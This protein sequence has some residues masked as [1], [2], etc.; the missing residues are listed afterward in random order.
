MDMTQKSSRNLNVTL[1]LL[2]AML[3]SVLLIIGLQTWLNFSHNRQQNEIESGQDLLELYKE[4]NNEVELQE[5]SSAALVNSFAVRPDVQQ[6]FLAR[7]RQG[8]LDLLTPIFTTLKNDYNVVHLY[9][10]E[11]EGVVF[12]RV[13]N[14]E[15]F[16]DSVTYRHTAAAAIESRQTT[17]GVEIG[18][19]RIGMRSVTPM[20]QQ[21]QVIGLVEV[22]LD[23]DQ[24][25]LDDLKARNQAD[26][27]LWVTF[28]AAAPANLKPVADAPASPQAEL[29]YYAGTNPASLPISEQVYTRVLESKEPEFHFVSVDD[30]ELA[31]LVAPVLGYGDR[32]IG[33]L[34]ISRAR[35]EALAALQRDQLTAVAVSGGLFL[36]ALAVMAILI[37]VV[38]SR[39]LRHLTLVS[40]RQLGGDLTSRVELLPA[41]EFGQLGHT[42]NALTEDLNNSLKDAEQASARLQLTLEVTQQVSAI[43]EVAALLK[44]VVNLVQ[45]RFNLYHTQIY[46]LDNSGEN[47]VLAEGYGEAG[48]AMIASDHRIAVNT[49][50]SVEAQAVRTGQIVRVDDVLTEADWVANPLLPETRSELAVPIKLDERVVGVLDVQSEREARFEPQTAA[51]LSTVANGIA[52]AIRNAQRFAEAQDALTKAEKLQQQYLQT[53]WRTFLTSQGI[54]TYQQVKPEAISIDESL[55]TQIKQGVSHGQKVVIGQAE[56]GEAENGKAQS[57][58]AVPLILRGQFIGNIRVHDTV[59]AHQWT[60]E[61]IALLES[62]SEQMSL[63]LENARLFDETR[64]RASR[65]QLTRQ[66][67]DRMRAA[68]DVDSIIET[69]LSELAKALGVSRTYVKLSPKADSSKIEA[70]R[71]QLKHNGHKAISATTS[72]SQ[73][74]EAD[75]PDQVEEK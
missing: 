12:V 34:E 43:L 66:I 16:G 69:G 70:I 11:P 10:H 63:A 72:V 49:L 33:I 23:Y 51:I 36:L 27:K 3:A 48:A 55:L 18:P 44:E 40:E 73:P 5:R 62:I 71:D 4:Y 21:D 17:A 30:Q 39:P 59:G 54:T 38:V 13:H 19:N 26:Y 68:P 31:A 28:E 41:D 32:V 67:T 64:Q 25:F 29:F 9:L 65:E 56:A 50:E 45:T 52:T 7:D 14:P 22:G 58:V 60:T 8:L 57:A 46:L 2:L 35:T 20:F 42:L 61:E 74:E 6:L 1:K 75:N 37:N 24:A 53:G 15:K 47:L